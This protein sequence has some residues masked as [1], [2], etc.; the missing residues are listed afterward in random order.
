[1]RIADCG[2]KNARRPLKTIRN[3]KSRSLRRVQFE[4]D[5]YFVIVATNKT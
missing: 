5:F 2:K 1:M 3:P 4:V